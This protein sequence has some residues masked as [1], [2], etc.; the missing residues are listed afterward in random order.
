MAAG[1]AF[2]DL[3]CHTAA[4]FDSLADP[5]AVARAAARRG[6]TH[7]VV[8]DHATSAGAI[9]ARA[10]A[11]AGLTVI[12]G[13]EIRTR[14]GDLTAAFLTEAIPP[15]LPADTV[16][17]AV[18]AQGGLVGIPHPFDRFR[19]SLSKGGAAGDRGR[20]AWLEEVAG[21]VDWIEAWNARLPGSGGNERAAALARRAGVPGVAASDAH[22]VMEVGVACTVVSGDPSTPHGLRAALA[23]DLELVRGRASYLVRAVTPV[24][25]LVQLAR[26][27]GRVPAG[28]AGGGE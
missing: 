25:K 15:G 23:G 4:S 19:G 1:R 12:V 26:G 28:S 3:H 8:T 14:D 21:R 11:P 17:D 22:T 18:H 5:A 7:L 16:I 9:A 27:R 6:I 20:E 2:I 24:A 10:A 13:E